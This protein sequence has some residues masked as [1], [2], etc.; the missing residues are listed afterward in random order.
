MTIFKME[1]KKERVVIFIDGNNFYH[2]VKRILKLDERVGY[3]RLVAIL[4]KERELINT[5]YYVAPLDKEI[6]YDNYEK[7]QNFLNE[8]SQIPKFKVVLCDFKKIKGQDGRFFYVVKG[9]DVRL[10]HDLLIGAFDN[11]YDTAV[12]V[13]GDEDFFPLIMTVRDRF[14]KRVENAFF[15]HSS[16]YKLRNA[17]NFSLGLNKFVSK[18]IVKK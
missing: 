17:C 11:T 14:K 3:Q 16:S 1:S 6:N 8:L 12:I 5:F 9:D 7:H 15:R 10:S 13:S 2:G 4:L 18:F